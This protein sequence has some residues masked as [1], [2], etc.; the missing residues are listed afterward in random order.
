MGTHPTAGQASPVRHL[1][2]NFRVLEHLWQFV[3]KLE[4]VVE[5]VNLPRDRIV[6]PPLE[7]SGERGHKGGEV[8]C[9][10]LDLIDRE[11]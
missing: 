6:L 1:S 9:K 2:G 5:T 4:R 3:P 7:I 11:F 8:L 10:V